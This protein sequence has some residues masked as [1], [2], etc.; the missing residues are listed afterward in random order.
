MRRWDDDEST[1]MV[2]SYLIR[3][4]ER[5]GGYYVAIE[6]DGKDAVILQ[7]NIRTMH[8][9]MQARSE[10]RQRFIDKTPEFSSYWGL[11]KDVS[12]AVDLELARQHN[13]GTMLDLHAVA[14]VAVT[15]TLRTLMQKIEETVDKRK[16]AN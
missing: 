2:F 4:D 9:A 12:A 3:R 6:E 15:L 5:S 10:W 16:A 11:L 14:D 13:T 8:K 1:R 7:R